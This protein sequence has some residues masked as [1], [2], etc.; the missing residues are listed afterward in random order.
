MVI[1]KKEKALG[2]RPAFTKT[3]VA[4]AI[5]FRGRIFAMVRIIYGTQANTRWRW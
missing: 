3:N 1:Q 4:S 5:L 2:G